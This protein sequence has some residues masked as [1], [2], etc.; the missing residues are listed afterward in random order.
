MITFISFAIF[1]A[2]L[3]MTGITILNAYFVADCSK[4]NLP[5]LDATP[6]VSVLIPAR[7]EENNLGTLLKSLSVQTYPNCEVFVLDDESEDSTFA[8]AQSFAEKYA[9]F[10]IINGKKLEKGWL[11]KPFA[12]YQLRNCAKGEYLL[13]LD[14]DVKLAP[15]AVER[16]MQL[17]KI[18]PE[19]GLL[20]CFPNQTCHSWAERLIVPLIDLV[21]YS[22]APLPLFERSLHP[23]LAAANGQCLLF[24]ADAYDAIGGHSAVKRE[25]LEDME[26]ARGS[27]R[28]G[29]RVRV[30][31]GKG[32]VECRMY[33]TI[34]EIFRGFGKN[35]FVALGGRGWRAVL[36]GSYFSFV[37][38]APIC[39]MGCSYW[40][41]V[42]VVLLVIIRIG[43]GMRFGYRV[44][45]GVLGHVPSVIF[46]LCI[47]VY[48]WG[49]FRLGRP[50][51][52]GRFVG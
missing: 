32:G 38:L 17:F 15:H 40:A 20:S 43:I 18:A 21:L 2:V 28:A 8:I 50:E 5:P 47:V 1:V 36:V 33:R 3:V 22:C 25:I 29:K 13:F 11:G 12:C 31:A 46:G 7:N 27:K 30:V 48:S 39:L 9:N 24:K 42:A 44:V 35:C 23:G 6:L 10:T 52:K 34:G 41:V 14:A 26:L 49:W 16:L 4:G 45:D 51:W 19:V 37:F